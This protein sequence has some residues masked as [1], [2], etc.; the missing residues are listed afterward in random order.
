MTHPLIGIST[1]ELRNPK[2]HVNRFASEPPMRELALGLTYPQAVAR[3]GGVPVVIP[4]FTSDQQID[5]LLERVDGICLAGGPDLHPS[6]YGE[7]PHPNL[8]PTEPALDGCELALARMALRRHLPLLCICRGL[9]ALNVA[10]GGTLIQDLPGHRQEEPG[11]IATHTVRIAPDSLLAQSLGATEVVEVNSFH[12]QAVDR[13]G[14]GLRA[15]AWAE[16]GLIEGIE[17]TDREFAVGVQ[18]HA[19]G[20]VDNAEQGRLFEAFM[21]ACRTPRPVRRAA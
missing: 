3:A 21:A 1:S 18:W 10:R 8:G 2:E 9:Q 5:A 20:L 6:L 16:D 11:R 12:H 19:E 7:E 14:D 13:L 4:P 15:V 17:A